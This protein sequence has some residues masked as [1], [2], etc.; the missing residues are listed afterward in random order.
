MGYRDEFMRRLQDEG[1]WATMTA[2]SQR[3]LKNLSDE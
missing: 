3:R 2:Q 1:S